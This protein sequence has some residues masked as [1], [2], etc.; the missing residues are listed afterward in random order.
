LRRRYNKSPIHVHIRQAERGCIEHQSSCVN[1]ERNKKWFLS[2]EHTRKQKGCQEKKCY[3]IDVKIV[4]N[5]IRRSILVA[6]Y[7]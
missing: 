1:E 4:Y 6:V 3:I 2:L 5:Y 7:I